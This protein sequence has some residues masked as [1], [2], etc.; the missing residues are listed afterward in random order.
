MPEG[1]FNLVYTTGVERES[2]VQAPLRRGSLKLSNRDAHLVIPGST[3]HGT[4]QRRG[5]SFSLSLPGRPPPLCSQTYARLPNP[6]R[7]RT[8]GGRS[9]PLAWFAYRRGP[10]ALP[11]V[12]RL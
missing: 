10:L 6:A 8:R 7:P 5:R 9:G 2:G 3:H 4:R 1:S 11:I 12:R